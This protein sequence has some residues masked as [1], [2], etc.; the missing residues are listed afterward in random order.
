LFPV[1]LICS[2]GAILIAQKMLLPIKNITASIG[3]VSAG[4][5][6][7][8]VP[9][10]II[11]DELYELSIIYNQMG[12]HIEKLIQTLNETVDNI[13]HD[14]KTPISRSRIAAE[15]ALKSGTLEDLKYAA[16]NN[17]EGCDSILSMIH[18][19]LLMARYDAKTLTLN[20][21]EFKTREMID[22]IVNLYRFVAEEK[23][24]K[25]NIESDES[26]IFA[27]RSIM[28]Q[29][30]ANLIDNAIKYS[31]INTTVTI[32]S[33]SDHFKHIIIVKDQGI[34]ISTDDSQKI[35][36][37]LYRAEKSRNEN[38]MGLGLSLVKTFVSAHEGKISVKSELGVGSEFTIE[39]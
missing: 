21:I 38:G 39:I 33:Y 24:I 7:S 23:N 8:R 9:E 17:I 4:K 32:K 3:E 20:K 6:S 36:E 37:R 25:V 16:E 31:P 34:G 19:I 18:A 14:L 27:D 1:L 5:L 13:A 15:L 10:P 28:K 30:L 11:H 35:W 12:N 29:C 26:L 2:W 22:E